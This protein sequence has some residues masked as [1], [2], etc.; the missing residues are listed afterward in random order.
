MGGGGRGDRGAPHAKEAAESAA[1]AAG[2]DVEAVY[3]NARKRDVDRMD[4]LERATAKREE[5]I[6][7]AARA[8]LLDDEEIT[9]IRGRVGVAGG[10]L[11]MGGGSRGDRGAPTAKGNC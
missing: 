5:E 1:G 6:E 9:R 4:F 8:V 10:G 11:G 7:A 3:E 2:L